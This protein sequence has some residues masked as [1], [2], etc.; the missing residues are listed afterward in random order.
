MMYLYIVFVLF[1][2]TSTGPQYSA[3]VDTLTSP[4]RLKAHDDTNLWV[5]ENI[6]HYT[7]CWYQGHHKWE[8]QSAGDQFV[9]FHPVRVFVFVFV[10]V[11]NHLHTSQGN[12]SDTSPKWGPVAAMIHHP[13]SSLTAKV[14]RK[15]PMQHWW[16][17]AANKTRTVVLISSWRS[18]HSYKCVSGYETDK[19]MTWFHIL[20]H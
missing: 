19:G 11:Y 7:I 4:W 6:V 18:D 14:M 5:L 16:G 10:S 12:T 13:V 20:R 1:I 15:E 17:L 8:R 2:V 9:V 3:H